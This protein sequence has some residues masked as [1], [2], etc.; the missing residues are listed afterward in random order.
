MEMSGEASYFQ[1]L[2]L[3]QGGYIA[4]TLNGRQSDPANEKNRSILLG[5]KAI[6]WFDHSLRS[7]GSPGDGGLKISPKWLCTGAP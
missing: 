6:Y 3:Q 7:S 5:R 2:S 4:S 1:M